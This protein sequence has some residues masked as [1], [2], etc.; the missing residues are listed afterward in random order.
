MLQRSL[1]EENSRFGYGFR[2]AYIIESG[3]DKDHNDKCLV[4]LGDCCNATL[5]E[6]I[7]FK[8]VSQISWT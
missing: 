7:T 6:L 8:K 4:I 2:D 5:G 3:T 1:K